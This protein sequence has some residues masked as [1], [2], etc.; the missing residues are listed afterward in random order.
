M[1]LCRLLDYL[2]DRAWYWFASQVLPDVDENLL[3]VGM[4]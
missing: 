4:G 1:I 3:D 2:L